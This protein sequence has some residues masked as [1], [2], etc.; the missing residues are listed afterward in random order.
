MGVA[1]FEP[2][3]ALA[4]MFGGV[5]NQNCRITVFIT[6]FRQDCQFT[7]NVFPP[8]FLSKILTYKRRGQGTSLRGA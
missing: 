5:L 3:Q 2:R 6:D 7:V 8:K 1:L 4:L